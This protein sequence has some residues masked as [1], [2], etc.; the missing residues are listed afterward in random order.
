MKLKLTRFTFLMHVSV[1]LLAIHHCILS[2]RKKLFGIIIKNVITMLLQCSNNVVTL[3]VF[4]APTIVVD[5]TV[6]YPK[7]Y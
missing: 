2:D 4:Q 3:N 5:C 1:L 7:Y 6:L